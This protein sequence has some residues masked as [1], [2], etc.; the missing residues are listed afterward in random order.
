EFERG[1]AVA[2]L[3]TVQ[4]WLREKGFKPGLAFK[5]GNGAGLLLPVPPT[6]PTPEFIAK[7]ATFLR[8]V[9][10]EAD[11]DVDTTTF[12]PPRVCGVLQTWNSKL[13]DEDEGRKNHLRQAIGDIPARD[14]DKA[15]LRYIEGLTPDHAALKTWTE[16]Y[17]QLPTNEEEDPREV[18]GQEVD[19]DFV[20]EKLDTLL[21]SDPT[22]RGLIDWTD[23]VKERHAGD[24]SRAEFGLIGKLT[25]AGFQDDQINWIMTHISRIGKWAEEG[26]HY[27]EVTLRKIRVKDADEVG[28]KSG[29]CEPQPIP[30]EPIA[31]DVLAEARYIL[32]HGDPIKYTLDVFNTL[33]V[34]DRSA[35]GIMYCCYLTPKIE[36]SRGAHPKLTGKSGGGKSDMA[37]ASLHTLPSET[38]IKTGLSPKALMYHSFPP[39]MIIYCDDYKQNDDIDTVIKQTSSN[40]HEPYNHMTVLKG[41]PATLSVPQETVWMITSVDSDQ[42]LQCLNRA[43]PI[44]VDETEDQ[45]RRVADHILTL[46][47]EGEIARPVTREV[48]ICRAMF[49]ILKSKRYKVKIPFAIDIVWNDFVNRRN[50]PLFLDVLQAITFWRRFQRDEDVEGRLL[51]TI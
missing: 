16:K 42:D 33:H 48:M 10:R 34:G 15:L 43:V 4:K 51:S 26:R 8:T 23:E 14:E 22:L 12:D 20:K 17:A 29:T 6:P 49:R 1:F 18:A 47:A 27:Q 28:E 41:K 19:V 5:S 3:P 44:D 46:A 24:R 9:K 25:K 30:P 32:E 39:G 38:Y 2:Q 37:E 11:V 13:E 40:F 36:T 45:D 50:L 35:G 21:E 31:E 7:V